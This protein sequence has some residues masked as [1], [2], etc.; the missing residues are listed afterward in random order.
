MGS[1]LFS[2]AAGDLNVSLHVFK[3]MANIKYYIKLINNYSSLLF[4]STNCL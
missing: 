1:S 4:L 2:S 3:I